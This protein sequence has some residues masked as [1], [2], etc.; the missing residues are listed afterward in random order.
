MLLRNT[1]IIL[2]FFNKY[3]FIKSKNMF[4]NINIKIMYY[5]ILYKSK[6]K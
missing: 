1:Y 2:V 5:F 6:I 3:L 4:I